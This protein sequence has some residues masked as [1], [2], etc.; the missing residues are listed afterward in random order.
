MPPSTG[1]SGEITGLTPAEVADRVAAGEQNRVETR[2]SRSTASILRA[3]IL[4]RFNA[5][6]AALLVLVLVFGEPKEG[7]FGLVMILNAVVG[8]GQELR[9]KRTLDRLTVLTAPKACVRRGGHEVEI[10]VGELVRDDVVALR[11]GD[12]VAVDGPVLV[13]DGLELDESLLTGEADAVTK[14]EGDTALSGSFVAVGSGLMRAEKIGSEAYARR[15]ADAAKEFTLTRSELKVGVDRILRIVT[16][17]IVPTSLFLF[18]SQV[19]R[20]SLGVADGVVSAVAG[21]EGMVPQGLV[22]LTSMALAVAV[23]RLGRRN[24]LVQEL[25]AVETLARVDVLCLDKTGTLTEGRI[26]HRSTESVGS[27]RIQ[28]CSGALAALAAGEPNPNATIAAIGEAHTDVP[29]WRPVTRVPFSSK[30]KWSATTFTET[31]TWVLGAP[32]VVLAGREDTA[33]VDAGREA[34]RQAEQGSRVLLL[35]R[36][37]QPLDA[38]PGG[39][40]PTLPAGLEPVALVLLGE[41]VRADATTTVSW[42]EAQGVTLKVISGDS[43]ATVGTIAAGVGIPSGRQPVDAMTLPEDPESMAA[44]METGSVFGRVTPPQKQ[45]MVAALQSRGHTVA[46]TG[47]GVNDV[48]ALKKADMGIAMGSGTAATKAVAQLI[49]IDGRFSVL[50]GVVAEG[51]RVIANIERVATLFLTKTVYSAALAWTVAILFGYA[52]PFTPI[53]LTFVGAVTIGIPAFFLSFEPAA[54]RA[55]PGFLPRVLRRAIPAGLVAATAVFV[56]YESAQTGPVDAT[57]AQARTAATVELSLV[58][59]Y[60]LSLVARPLNLLRAVVL[61]AMAGLFAVTLGVG[62]VAAFFELANPPT[63]VWFTIVPAFGA[64]IVVL[65]VIWRWARRRE[66]ALEA[67][68][69]AHPPVEERV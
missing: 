27:A 11:A 62:P 46:M 41:Q 43:P 57:L 12:Q 69:P 18:W 61:A 34:E 52:Y 35:A 49:L 59:L 65:E 40:D 16:W 21:V 67:V 45:A 56:V 24:A 29:G 4:T 42:F 22:L 2:T 33:A 1:S 5:I 15:L 20:G 6:V 50:P 51:R 39:T 13:S 30:R 64:A 25:P 47:D 48:L 37:P 7:L 9:A 55:R 23:I 68:S 10:G 53:H 28:E 60:V 36:S 44:H 14:A 58:G 8:I 63:D 66:A 3:N 32:E 54:D 26:V 17:I 31:G 38:A 19:F